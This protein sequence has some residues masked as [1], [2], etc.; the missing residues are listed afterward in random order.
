[1]TSELIHSSNKL[2]SQWYNW[3]INNYNSL[4]N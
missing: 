1:M 4:K 2:R 3:Y